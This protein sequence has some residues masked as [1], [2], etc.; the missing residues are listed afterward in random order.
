MSGALAKLWLGFTF[1][2]AFAL[3]SPA[4]FAL[5]ARLPVNAVPVGTMDELGK[6]LFACWAPPVGTEGS[7]ITFRFGLTAK[8]ELRGK[9]LASYS[10]LTGSKERQRAFVEAA[11]LALSR[12]TP[13]RMTEQFARVAASR[14]LILRFVS[15]ERRA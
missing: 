10:V 2:M 13:V 15:G 1:A 5:E 8:G 6:A 11:L 3:A 12:C 14:V 4:G 7:E 9:P